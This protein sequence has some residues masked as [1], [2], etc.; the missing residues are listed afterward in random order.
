MDRIEN[1]RAEDMDTR[2]IRFEEAMTIVHDITETSIVAASS[3][4]S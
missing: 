1:V 3:S 4:F 2:K